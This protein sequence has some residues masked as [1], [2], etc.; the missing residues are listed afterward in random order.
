MNSSQQEDFVLSSDF[1]SIID[2]QLDELDQDE[3]NEDFQEQSS[4]T[5][6]EED[7]DSEN[8]ID[9]PLDMLRKASEGAHAKSTLAGYK[10]YY[11]L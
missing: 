8:H 3:I 10:G 5:A 7:L 6:A 4:T 2:A 9:L 11:S 1:Q